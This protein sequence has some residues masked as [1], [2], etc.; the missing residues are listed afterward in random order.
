MVKNDKVIKIPLDTFASNIRGEEL[1]FPKY[2]TQIINLAN[3][4]AQGTRP[5]VV[6]QMSELIQE[7]PSNDYV[8]W[9]EWYLE[10]MPNAVDEATSR[11]VDM[12]EKF[13]KVIVQIDEDMVRAWV[14]DLL[15]TKTFIGLKAQQGILQEVAKIKGTSY[16]LAT[17][18]EEAKG[19]DGYVGDIPISVKPTTYK[20]KDML[21]ESID[22]KIVYYEKTKDAIK[23]DLSDL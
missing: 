3:Q 9:G 20:S 15:I 7:C 13:K 4:N 14:E 11:I 10:T 16:R 6:G 8:E 18:D 17:P 12:I 22:V 23:I 21:R 5:N 2:A 1:L 19:I